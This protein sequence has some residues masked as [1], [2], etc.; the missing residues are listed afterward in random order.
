MVAAGCGSVEGAS[1]FSNNDLCM[2]YCFAEPHPIGEMNDKQVA[3][4]GCRYFQAKTAVVLGA[5][6]GCD[7]AGPTGGGVCGSSCESYCG[8]AKALCQGENILYPDPETCLADCATLP[9]VGDESTLYGNSVQCRMN[10]LA[11][12]YQGVDPALACAEGSFGGGEQCAE[13]AA[14]PPTTY[15]EHVKPIFAARCTPCHGVGSPEPGSCSGSAC[16][17]SVFEDLLEPSYY[18]P[19]KTKGACTLERILDGSMPLVG[20]SP[21]EDEIGIIQTWLLDGMFEQ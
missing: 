11:T 7:A 6:V 21:N 5:E 19:G 18:C 12:G 2:A 1:P 10:H 17:T 4:I 20:V 13:G 9:Q 14:P 15:V 16:F 3:T 8:L